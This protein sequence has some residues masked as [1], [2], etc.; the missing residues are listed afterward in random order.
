MHG[1]I[2]ASCFFGAFIGGFVALQ[3]HPAIWW[4]GMCIGAIA[5]YLTYEVNAVWAAISKAYHATCSWT[6]DVPYWKIVTKGTLGMA[7]VTQTILA[8]SA[9]LLVYGPDPSLPIPHELV[10]W[11]SIVTVVAIFHV[12]V[13]FFGFIIHIGSSKNAEGQYS[14]TPIT[15]G[16]TN[17][18][19]LLFWH[20][21]RGIFFIVAHSP[22]MLRSCLGAGA[23]CYGF[24][25]PFSITLFREIHSDARLLCACDAAI[26]T[27]IGYFTGNVILGAIAGGIFGILNYEVISKRLLHLEVRR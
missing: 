15:Y 1:K 5:G 9:F 10:Q 3:M 2:F 13:M 24:L 16:A 4:I 22:Q 27:A 18:I 8:C 19:S 25:K 7:G 6:P 20:L 17:P 11:K 23:A 26:G 12:G 21:P 14:D